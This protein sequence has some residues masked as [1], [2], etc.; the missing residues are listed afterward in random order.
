MKAIDVILTSFNRLDLLKVTLDSFFKH[1]TYPITSFT[2]YDDYGW[3]KMT[4]QQRNKLIDLVGNYEVQLVCGTQRI[5]QIQAI[6]TLV[7]NVTTPY[8][9]HME[10]DWEFIRPNFIQDSIEVL[11]QHPEIIQCWLRGHDDT[12]GHPIIKHNGL[13]SYMSTKYEWKGFSF[14]PAVRR[15]ADY[16]PYNDICQFNPKD[17][18]HSEKIIGNY[19]HK[20]G[21]RACILNHA[22]VRHIGVN[23]TCK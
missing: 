15:L 10:D 19:Y 16:T 17:P 23:R 21:F 1:N 5:G 20:K 7:K 13:F 14:N 9:F 4:V 22:Y 6:D 8:Y 11:E 3:D 12:N 2:I 18:A